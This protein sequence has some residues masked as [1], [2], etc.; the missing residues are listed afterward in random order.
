[1][2][3]K[4]LVG[5]GSI[6]FTPFP[7][8]KVVIPKTLPVIRYHNEKNRDEERDQVDR[9]DPGRYSRFYRGPAQGPMRSM[10]I[11]SLCIHVPGIVSIC[12]GVQF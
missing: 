3:W 7:C 11:V 9:V 8:T 2:Q 10:D 5:A 12:M 1:M 4:F 6:L